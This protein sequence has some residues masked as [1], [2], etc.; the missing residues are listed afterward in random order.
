[1]VWSVL[2]SFGE[3]L[4]IRRNIKL[5]VA[6]MSV[7]AVIFVI[8]VAITNPQFLAKAIVAGLI[9]VVLP[10]IVYLYTKRWFYFLGDL[11]DR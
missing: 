6:T 9:V 5:I 3:E 7:V 8:G 4:R 10:V 11:F 1:M 2:E